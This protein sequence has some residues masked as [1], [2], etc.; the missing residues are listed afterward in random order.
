MKYGLL[1]LAA[2]LVGAATFVHA[3]YVIIKVNLAT[4]R[5]KE[6]PD[7]AGTMPGGMM[8]G[9]PG[10][11]MPGM[12][13]G[14]Q[15]GMGR[16][17][18]G[19]PG[20]PGGGMMPGMPGGMQPGMGRGLGG[21]GGGTGDARMGGG[22]GDARMG[23]GTGD[24]RMG[25]GRGGK[26]GG[27]GAPSDPA[28][29]TP[30]GMGG[31]GGMMGQMYSEDD[32]DAQTSPLYVEAVIEVKHGDIKKGARTGRERIKH[33]WGET[34]LPFEQD[35]DIEV[36][37][38]AVLTVAQRFEENKKLI[39]PN[40]P[41]RADKL[42]DLAEWALQHGLLDKMREVMNE[43][44]KQDPK[45]KAVTDFRKIQSALERKPSRVDPVVNMKDKLGIFKAINS[46][47]YVLLTDA[48]NDA[49]SQRRLKRLE[50]N[51]YGFFY[52]FALRGEVLPVPDYRLVAILEDKPQ[53][54]EHLHEKIFDN[55]PMVNDGFYA[56]RENLA[57][58]STHRLD[59]GYRGLATVYSTLERSL[60]TVRS[61]LLHGEDPGKKYPMN[62]VAKAQTYALLLQALEEES[63]IATVSHEGTRQLIA[64]LGLL[65]RNVEAPQWIDFGTASFFETPKGSFWT[66]VGGPSERYLTNFKIWQATNKLDVPPAEALKKVVTDDYFRKVDGSKNKER[67]L[68]KARTMTWSL[69]YY[70]AQK[71]RGG[72][73]RY[74]RE[75]DN[76]PRDME[77]DETVLM[78]LFA[79]AFD[80][81]DLQKPGQVDANKLAIMANDWYRQM[82]IL[83]LEV[84]DE[85]VREARAKAKKKKGYDSTPGA[86]PKPG[87][88]KPSG[89]R[90]GGGN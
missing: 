87:G 81:E 36:K 24:A 67:A 75:L 64:A 61:D 85:A 66:G 38:I 16:G 74:Y 31:R 23:G 90:P 51:F 21:P 14:M 18:G 33:R 34:N 63:E 42:L 2:L 17:L 57:V 52:W 28:G 35:K 8:P 19:Q 50:D 41:N 7:A 47:H 89:N 15:P 62:E 48:L 3:D 84:N 73:L 9:M 4:N 54:F 69:V 32:E 11:M 40:D 22:T 72:L 83:P 25:G 79:R 71:K 43:M 29:G 82:E 5:E 37:K 26:G 59:P 56:R 53:Q 86:T 46:D 65:P 39:K 12:P 77:F 55:I 60:N 80:L 78:G 1:A 58:F 68:E 20:M 13:G 30:M 45:H 88:N 44:A 10:G 6:E 76:V 49:D 70:L 27:L